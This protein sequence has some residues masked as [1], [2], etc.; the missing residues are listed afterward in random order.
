MHPAMKKLYW[1][2][3]VYRIKFKLAL[4]MF[5]IYIHQ[6]AYHLTDSVHPNSQGSFPAGTPGNG[7]P[8]V[9][10]AVGM[11]FKPALG[12]LYKNHSV[13]SKICLFEI[14]N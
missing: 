14:Q 11:A 8:K 12:E 9:I 6:C 7:V 2:P 3:V 5:T 1:L 10:L 4:V 13:C